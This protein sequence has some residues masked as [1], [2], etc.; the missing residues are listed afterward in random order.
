MK[1][2][3]PDHNAIVAKNNDL[4]GQLA[5]FELSELRLLAYC[6]AHYDSR[7]EENREVVARVDDLKQIFQM[8]T[9]DAYAVVRRAMIGINRK[10]Y[11]HYEEPDS[12]VCDFWFTRFTYK[13]K[14]GEF[15]F[16]IS[17]EMRPHLLALKGSFTQYRLADVYQFRRA[18]TWKLYENLAQW[19]SSR[20]WAVDLD[21]LRTR[22]GVAGKYP[23][24]YE[25]ERRL[26]AP[27]IA[28]INEYSDLHVEYQQEK[29]GR[30]VVGLVFDIRLKEP[31]EDSIIIVESGEQKIYKALL[32]ASVTPKKADSLVSAARHSG[33]VDVIAAKLAKKIEDSKTKGSPS[34]Y[35]VRWIEGEARQRDL[36]CMSATLA[37][38]WQVQEGQKYRGVHDGAVWEVRKDAD[39]TL[40]C[41][42]STTGRRYQL[43]ELQSNLDNNLIRLVRE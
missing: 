1:K 39:G 20:R 38:G 10:P 17:P 25:V 37:N 18:S 40:Y 24:W 29:R 3:A 30:S 7:S 21:E 15:T 12:W 31:D 42:G 4:V 34:G 9:K 5:K 13:S 43:A 41:Y 36:P 32:A 27:A 16:T 6:L 14:I 19:R 33:K 22:L 26:I 23:Q 28:E 8:T 2:N 11:E 35:L